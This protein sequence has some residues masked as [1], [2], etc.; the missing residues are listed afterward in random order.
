MKTAF[1]FPGQGSQ[2]VGMGLD[3]YHEFDFVRELF[4]MAEETVKMKLKNLCFKGPMEALTETV[5]LQPAVTAANLACLAVLER[6]AI[7]AQVTAGHSLGE[8]SALAAAGVLSPQDTL[9]AVFRR[10]QLMHREAQKHPG[11]M[12]AIVGLSIDAVQQ[13]VTDAQAHGV[14]SVAN[15]NTALQIVISG[16]PGPVQNAARTAHARGARTIPLNV[17]GAWHS[18]LIQGAKGEF[19]AFLQSL[20]FNAPQ[21][22]V[23]FNV[24]A[25]LCSDP[26]EMRRLLAEQLCNPVRWYDAMIRL[27]EDGV[28]TFVEVG[29]GR[30]LSGI[31]KKIL[32]KAH[33][34][35]VFNVG[36]LKSLEAFLTARAKKSV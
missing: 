29:P 9:R 21:R 32:P 2:F 27:M 36:D 28:E 4:D 11:T 15:H 25:D 34:G 7:G 13:I 16:S 8:Y 17:S 20:S 24:T 14:V 30:V 6:E 23:I 5:N 10:G 31:Q 26:E 12:V 18:P 33:P 22:E 3:F 1:L 19:G 35:A